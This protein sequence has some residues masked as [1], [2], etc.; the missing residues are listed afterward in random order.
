MASSGDRKLRGEMVAAARRS[1]APYAGAV[2]DR[3]SSLTAGVQGLIRPLARTTAAA[4]RKTFSS[5]QRRLP[6]GYSRFHD[7]RLSPS[8]K[9]GVD[10]PQFE[11]TR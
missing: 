1:T 7:G 9:S 11:G 10:A 4:A 6:L 2:T 5:F 8:Q 3:R